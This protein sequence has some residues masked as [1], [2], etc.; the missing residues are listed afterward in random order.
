MYC[1][2]YIKLS[3]TVGMKK[4]CKALKF[5]NFITSCLIDGNSLDNFYI[6]FIH[7]LTKTFFIA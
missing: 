5:K 4:T 6:S 7:I 3:T 1:S 2:R